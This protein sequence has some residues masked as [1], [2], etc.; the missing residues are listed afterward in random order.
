MYTNWSTITKTTKQA[1]G[2]IGI[3]QAKPNLLNGVKLINYSIP[4]WISYIG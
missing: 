2:V 1:N 3:K 4:D